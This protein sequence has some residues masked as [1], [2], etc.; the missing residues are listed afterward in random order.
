MAD[1]VVNFVSENVEVN[2]NNGTVFVCVVM[3]GVTQEELTI[4]I[5]I[6]FESANGEF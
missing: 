4:P 5:T 2:E 3:D 6:S 1:V